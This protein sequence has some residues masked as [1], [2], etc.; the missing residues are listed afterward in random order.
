MLIKR[1]GKGGRERGR[2][3]SM[4]ER[5]INWLPLAHAPTVD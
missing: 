3:P 5:N 1:E 2:E 4:G